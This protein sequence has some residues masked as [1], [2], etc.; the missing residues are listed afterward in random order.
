[1]SSPAITRVTPSHPPCYGVCCHL[2]QRCHRYHLVDGMAGHTHAISTCQIGAEFPL[3]LERPTAHP[4]TAQPAL[5]TT[6]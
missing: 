5:S 1:M 6:N 3:F 4:P 2:H